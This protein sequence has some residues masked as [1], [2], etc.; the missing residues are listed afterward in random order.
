MAARMAESCS[1]V[2]SAVVVCATACGCG[3][4]GSSAKSSP[5]A[6]SENAIT[7]V[8]PI[9]F[10]WIIIVFLAI[11][12]QVVIDG[13]HAPASRVSSAH[14]LSP[15]AAHNLHCAGRGI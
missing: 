12:N 15:T 13:G 11:R 6:L 9:Q 3:P 5:R 7:H 1:G 2:F 14:I 8:R 4:V 10:Q